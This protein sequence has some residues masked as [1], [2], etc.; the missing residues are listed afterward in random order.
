MTLND[1]AH[2]YLRPHS[3]IV[4]VIAAMVFVT[5]VVFLVN[6]ES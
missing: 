6:K 3:V 4:A 1:G 2:F 5:C